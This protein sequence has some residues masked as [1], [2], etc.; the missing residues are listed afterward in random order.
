ML[1]LF[2]DWWKEAKATGLKISTHDN[3][4]NTVNKLIAFLKHDDAQKITPDDIVRFKDHRLS[5]GISPKTVNDGDLAALKTVLGWGKTNR[6]LS[7]NAVEGI[8]IKLKKRKRQRPKGFTHDEAKAL[9]HAADN[10]Q[11]GRRET[12]KIYMAKR[13]VPWIL[14]YTG[15][16][17]GE[18]AQLRKQDV[19]QVEGHHVIRIAPEAGT[20]KTD[21]PR[22]VVLHTHP[23]EMGF[24][25]FVASSKEDYLFLKPTA[26]GSVRGSLRAVKNRLAEFA[27][28]TVTDPNVQPNHGW[29]HRH[30]TVWLEAGLSDRVMHYM[31]GH[32]DDEGGPVHE[33]YGDVTI[34]AQ[35]VALSKFPRQGE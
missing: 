1:A 34:K 15:A 21:E 9:L 10:H 4:R 25:D 24:L 29:R 17:V 18:I 30:T 22:D 16:R 26:D 5:T 33:D 3:Y 13:W 11:R 35:I 19:R 28:E 32:E 23:I 12:L 27:R 20:V 2:G 7:Y 6:R 14:A 31:H 8:T